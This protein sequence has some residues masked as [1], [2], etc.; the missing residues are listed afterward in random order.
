MWIID[1]HPEARFDAAEAT[2]WYLSQDRSTAMRFADAL[3]E[4]LDSLRQD[5][6]SYATIASDIRAKSI[7]GFPYQLIFRAENGV[8]RLFA[9][10]H[11]SRRAGY[12]N[13]RLDD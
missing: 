7:R 6:L 11:H 10:A 8:I 9:V 3:E 2:D 1:F 13:A 4:D 12:W 5:P